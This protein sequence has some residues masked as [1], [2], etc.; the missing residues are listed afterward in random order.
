MEFAVNVNDRV[1]NQSASLVM[2]FALLVISMPHQQSLPKY[3]VKSGSIPWRSDTWPDLIYQ[4][5]SNLY[6]LGTPFKWICQLCVKL[7]IWIMQYQYG[8]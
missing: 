2:I 3:N 6:K 4:T 1:W 8:L 5:F 7:N